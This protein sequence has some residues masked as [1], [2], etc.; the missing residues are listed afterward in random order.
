MTKLGQKD[1]DAHTA[2]GSLSPNRSNAVEQNVKLKK[3]S[4][5]T[6]PFQWVA[7]LQGCWEREREARQTKQ[8]FG[9]PQK[10]FEECLTSYPVELGKELECPGC[11]VE[12]ACHR[13]KQSSRLTQSLSLIKL[14]P[15]A[16]LIQSRVLI[17]IGR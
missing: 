3:T 10:S 14:N 13:R 16:K 12:F 4:S 5:H 11:L 6:E 2:P 17:L 1:I 9:K 8:C 7:L 15:N